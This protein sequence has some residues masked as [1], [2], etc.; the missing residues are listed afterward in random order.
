MRFGIN[1]ILFHY[2]KEVLKEYETIHNGIGLPDI[3]LAIC[4]A[5]AWI[6]IVGVLI[7]GV[8]SSG[9]AAYFLGEPEHTLNSKE[10]KKKTNSP[11]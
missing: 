5:C 8:Q 1:F 9:K 3:Y 11:I 7:K 10:M 2:R 4:L 6:F